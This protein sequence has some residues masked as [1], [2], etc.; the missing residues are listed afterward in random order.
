M[1]KP[2][3]RKASKEEYDEA[4]YLVDNEDKIIIDP[5][6]GMTETTKVKMA[7][8]LLEYCKDQDEDANVCVQVM[9]IGDCVL[10]CLPGEVF[11]QFGDYIK[12]NTSAD[13]YIISS[14]SN[15]FDG[16]IPTRELFIPTI[17]ESRLSVSS[18]LD[19][20]AGYLITEKALEMS[21]DL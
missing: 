20:E 16:Y 4:K 17:Y 1:Q 7:R 5:S 2:K 13:K 3:K 18:F 8:C 11:V 9:K 6:K 12:E 14:L 21:K 19:P 15:G 10:Y